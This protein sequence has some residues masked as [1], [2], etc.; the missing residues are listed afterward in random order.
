MECLT[1]WLHRSNLLVF[2]ITYKRGMKRFDLLLRCVGEAC[3]KK[4]TK[5]DQTCIT[6]NS[7]KRNT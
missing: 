7:I 2:L 3:A 6:E 5:H 4:A 1:Q